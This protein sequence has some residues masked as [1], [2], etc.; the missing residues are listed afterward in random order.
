MAGVDGIGFVGEEE[1]TTTSDDM[2]YP[3]LI[4]HGY[5]IIVHADSST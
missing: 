1:V 3:A 2:A 4:S 5:T